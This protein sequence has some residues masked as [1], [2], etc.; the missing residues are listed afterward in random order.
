MGM[1][2]HAAAIYYYCVLPVIRVLE[3][4]ERTML[5]DVS[6]KLVPIDWRRMRRNGVRKPLG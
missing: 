6:R 1:I 5:L 3:I 2:V 4:A